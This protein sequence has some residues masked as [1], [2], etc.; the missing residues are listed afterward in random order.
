MKKPMMHLDKVI[1]DARLSSDEL[2]M[3]TQYEN[4]VISEGIDSIRLREMMFSRCV[5]N[6][7]N[8]VRSE[9]L[10]VS[11]EHCDFSNF[12]FDNSHIY[13]SEFRHCKLMAASLYECFIKDVL[14]DRCMMN[15]AN[16]SSSKIED[17][18]LKGCSCLESSFMALKHK[19]MAFVETRLEGSNFSET[20]LKGIDL[21][22]SEFV[23]LIYSPQLLKGLSVNATQA[24]YILIS[25]GVVIK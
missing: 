12:E 19:K 15:Y 20:A 23:N 17:V 18:N 1:S 25:M 6:G 5:F 21:S 2:E 8:F 16:F 7:T 3:G 24:E 9:I 22:Q 13:R 10:D 14:F 4:C 11:F